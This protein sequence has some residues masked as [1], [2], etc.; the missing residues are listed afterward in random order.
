MGITA[1]IGGLLSSVVGPETAAAIAPVLVGAG[2]GAAFGAG[3]SALT[4]GNI[5]EGALFGGLAGGVTSGL[6]EVFSGTD[7]FGGVTS[8]GGAAS[9]TA[10]LDQAAATGSGTGIAGSAAPPAATAPVGSVAGPAGTAPTD[11]ATAAATGGTPTDPL[12]VGGA[13]LNLSGAA[14]TGSASTG[15][16]SVGG[17]GLNLSDASAQGAA[18][19][20]SVPSVPTYGTTPAPSGFD[21]TTIGKIANSLGLTTP[22][23]D[24]GIIADALAKNPGILLSG[25]SMLYSLLSNAQPKGLNQLESQ[26]GQMAAQGSQL[27]SY[28]TSG[29][30]PPGAQTAINQ[31]VASAKAQIRSQFASMGQSGSTAEQEALQ[32]VDINAVV[33]QFKIADQLLQSGLQETNLSAT[34]YADLTKINQ[35]S[36]ESTGS[37]IASFAAALAGTTPGLTRKLAA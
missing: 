28:V 33:Q 31:A 4:G 16:L 17:A 12:S 29:T 23:Q 10:T 14:T 34:A 35:A 2:E 27:E 15:P 19:S 9:P 8:T 18:P 30:L 5:G 37:A 22:G 11:L 1:A 20:L 26:A 7:I 13:N 3:T 24:P 25:G 21:A 6:G 32:Q 36:A